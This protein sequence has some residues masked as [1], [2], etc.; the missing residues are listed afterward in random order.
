MAQATAPVLDS[1]SGPQCSPALSFL[2]CWQFLLCLRV[3]RANLHNGTS[4]P[5]VPDLEAPR[6]SPTSVAL[7]WPSL[8][9]DDPLEPFL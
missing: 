6:V 3:R 5:V 9:A 7:C 2:S 8:P 1:T 4:G